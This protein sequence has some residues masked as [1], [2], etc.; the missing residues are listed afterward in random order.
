MFGNTYVV[1]IFFFRSSMHGSGDFER[2]NNYFAYIFV[3]FRC[4]HGGD[5][6]SKF[7]K[8]VECYLRDL[9]M[10]CVVENSKLQININSRDQFTLTDLLS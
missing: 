8:I 5:P 7:W 6:N 10:L 3:I 9:V 4:F 1:N 2:V